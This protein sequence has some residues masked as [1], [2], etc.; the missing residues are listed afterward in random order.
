MP[1]DSYEHSG[2]DIQDGTGVCSGKE[3]RFGGTNIPKIVQDRHDCR[4]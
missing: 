3:Q 4:W 1:K 2:R